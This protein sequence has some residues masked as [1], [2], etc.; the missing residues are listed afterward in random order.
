MTNDCQSESGSVVSS[1]ALLDARQRERELCKR[2]V[3]IYCD[4]REPGYKR[5]PDGPNDAGNWTHLY[6]AT[7]RSN[8]RVLCQA[9][10]IFARER[11][12]RT[13]ASEEDV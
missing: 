7:K 1:T 2:D 9:S 10:S 11:F 3:C 5:T 13:Q 4:G 8:D 6:T 12:E